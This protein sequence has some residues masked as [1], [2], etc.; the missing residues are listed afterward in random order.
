MLADAACLYQS[1]SGIRQLSARLAALEQADQAPEGLDLAAC[2]FREGHPAAARPCAVV[3]AIIDQDGEWDVLVLPMT[4]SPPLDPADAVEIPTET[5][6]RLGLDMDRS[7]IMQ[8]I[9]R[10]SK[11][12]R[13]PPHGI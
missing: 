6:R 1:L 13:R 8:E 5:K 10:A 3:M 2:G 12:K 7:W 9:R 4:H 11:T